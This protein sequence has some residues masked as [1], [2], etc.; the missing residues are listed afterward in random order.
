MSSFNRDPQFMRAIIIDHYEN[1]E[2]FIKEND[3]KKLKNYSS[4]NNN[5]PSCIDNLTIYVFIKNQKIVDI[6]FTGVGCAIA[7]SSTDIMSDLLINQSVKDALK[8]IDNYLAMIDQQP[9]DESKLDLLYL[10]ENVNKQ[11]NRINCAKVGIN[12]IKNAILQYEKK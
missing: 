4:C 12:A 9:F 11:A 3:T 8:I 5:S 1:P 7:T 10:Y 6:K 2:H